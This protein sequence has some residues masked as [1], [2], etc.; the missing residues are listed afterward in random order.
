MLFVHM[1]K[2]ALE[3]V[4]NRA[5]FSGKGIIVYY[6]IH[7]SLTSMR[8]VCRWVR[9]MKKFFTFKTLR[10]KYRILIFL[11]ILAFIC[12]WF[13]E[14]F[15]GSSNTTILLHNSVLAFAFILGT[16]IADWIEL[17]KK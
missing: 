14:F 3:S 1:G 15:D 12:Q 10:N 5:F 2:S 13:S 11:M 17:I 16:L 4:V 9:D 7:E 8:K 6:Q